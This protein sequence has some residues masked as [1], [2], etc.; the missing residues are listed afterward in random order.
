MLAFI[1]C[2]LHST[3][4]CVLAGE[5][6]EELPA[7]AVFQGLGFGDDVPSY[8]RYEGTIRNLRI[9]RRTTVDLV[10]ELCA[11]KAAHEALG[12]APASIIL[13]ASPSAGV[14]APGSPDGGRHDGRDSDS[15]LE[16][17]GS[18]SHRPRSSSMLRSPPRSP[19]SPHTQALFSSMRPLSSHQPHGHHHHFPSEDA[20]GAGARSLTSIDSTTEVFVPSLP[21]LPST[22][23]MAEFFECFLKVKIFLRKACF[24]VLN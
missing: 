11:A 2:R 8:L 6:E 7:D 13:P 18:R 4:R 17:V 24:C 15:D 20:E 19:Q 10:H 14:G 3:Y 22:C 16:S 12:I 23:T 1:Q 5:V 21:S 9:S